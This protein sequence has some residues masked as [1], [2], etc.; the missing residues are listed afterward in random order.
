[1]RGKPI[2][3]ELP[4]T[5]AQWDSVLWALKL[6]R[7]RLRGRASLEFM[8]RHLEEAAK[9]IREALKEPDE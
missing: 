7:D 4:L 3:I 9:Q 8:D 6:G 5:H 1:M 2:A